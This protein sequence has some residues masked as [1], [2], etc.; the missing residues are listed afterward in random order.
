[1][2]Q[3]GVNVALRELVGLKIKIKIK[4]GGGEVVENFRL[5]LVVRIRDFALK[6]AR[7]HLF[8]SAPFP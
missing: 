6:F 3:L 8:A 2:I 4:K 5:Q 7:F 1:V